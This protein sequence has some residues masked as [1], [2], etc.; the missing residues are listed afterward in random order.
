MVMILAC[1]ILMVAYELI[2][3]YVNDPEFQTNKN[4]GKLS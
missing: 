4:T 2:Y 1:A 3:L